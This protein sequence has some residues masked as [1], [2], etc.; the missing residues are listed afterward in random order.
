MPGEGGV[1]LRETSAVGWWFRNAPE[2]KII[3]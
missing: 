2:C 3:L 1:R